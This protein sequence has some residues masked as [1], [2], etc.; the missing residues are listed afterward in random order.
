MQKYKID[1][2]AAYKL[3]KQYD[4]SNDIKIIDALGQLLLSLNEN[5]N[6]L[7]L[8]EKASIYDSNKNE[9]Y[10]IAQTLRKMHKENKK[11]RLTHNNMRS[12]EL[13][14]FVMEKNI[15]YETFTKKLFDFI[16][17]L[18]REFMKGITYFQRNSAD[19]TRDRPIYHRTL[20][21][22]NKN[23]LHELDCSGFYTNPDEFVQ[24]SKKTRKCTIERQIYDILFS[25]YFPTNEQ[26]Y[27]HRFMKLKTTREYF[28]TCF[29]NTIIDVDIE[30]NHHGL[31]IDL[32]ISQGNATKIIVE[33][34][35]KTIKSYDPNLLNWND[36]FN[37]YPDRIN[38]LYKTDVN[39]RRLIYDKESCLKM[40]S[41]KQQSFYHPVDK[42][43]IENQHEFT[44]K[45]TY[46]QSQAK[47]QIENMKMN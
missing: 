39:C 3:S 25:K 29:P 37:L 1:I 4:E 16:A 2:K 14:N 20:S 18:L 36:I 13:I 40:Y 38:D 11:Y 15:M 17:I 35:K 31:P 30:F 21:C 6:T 9:L 23:S 44:N 34:Y 8:Q 26:N 19:Q 33:N 5:P 32:T 28:N 12:N 27:G 41:K 22:G 42:W 10:N 46:S 47:T 7:T 43:I 45:N 24:R